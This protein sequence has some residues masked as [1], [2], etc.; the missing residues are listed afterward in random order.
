MK[1]DPQFLP[2][3][4]LNWRCIKDLNVRPEIIKLLEVKVEKKLL[5]VGLDFL[6]GW[7]L[8]HKQ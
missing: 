3:T 1:L 8:K 4:K 5:D 6:R 2:L 7:H